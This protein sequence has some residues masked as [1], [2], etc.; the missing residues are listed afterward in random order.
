MMSEKKLSIAYTSTDPK[1]GDNVGNQN[2]IEGP[3]Q[4]SAT[5][6]KEGY[7]EEVENSCV[8]LD[9]DES[10]EQTLQ[11]LDMQRKLA[12][13]DQNDLKK[14]RSENFLDTRANSYIAYRG[15]KNKGR[16]YYNTATT[17]R[18]PYK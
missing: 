17:I 11:I 8:L 4:F 3:C 12:A 14:I 2:D 5:S 18:I 9:L 13:M 15:N 1:T 10:A 7:H 16:D 6:P